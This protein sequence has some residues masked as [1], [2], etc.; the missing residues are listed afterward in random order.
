MNACTLDDYQKKKKKN[1]C[2]SIIQRT[3]ELSSVLAKFP[4]SSMAGKFI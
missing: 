1:E 3:I 4:A 2:L